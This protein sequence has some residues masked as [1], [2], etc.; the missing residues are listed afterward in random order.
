MKNLVDLVGFGRKFLANPDYPERVR[1]GAAL[2]EI[3]DT[4][5]LFGGGGARWYTDYEFLSQ[6]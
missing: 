5:T 1:T 4:H 3:S 2:N 6:Q